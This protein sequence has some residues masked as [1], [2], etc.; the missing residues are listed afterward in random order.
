MADNIVTVLRGKVNFCKLLPDQLHLNY[1]KEGKEWKTD[2]YDFDTKEVKSLGIA[3]RVKSKDEYL[4][5][6]DHM[7]FKQKEF[8]PDGKAND[9]IKIVDIAGKPW[10]G[11]EIGNGSTVDLKFA[12]K[13]YGK[14]KKK[15][16]YIRSMRVLDHVPFTRSEF[17]PLDESDEFF[18]QAQAA[19]A[20]DADRREREDAQFKKDFDLEDEVPF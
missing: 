17:A 1:G 2:F 9:P 19:A 10:T 4:D 12:V 5:G 11:G 6:K 14:G 16:V 18:K 13:D 3:D 8:R 20:L 15:G 7:T